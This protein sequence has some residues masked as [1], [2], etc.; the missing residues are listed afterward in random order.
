MNFE[1]TI[2]PD[3]ITGWK[4]SENLYGFE[5]FAI[6]TNKDVWEDSINSLWTLVSPIMT[7]A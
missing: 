6:F 2:Q 7:I 1:S 4:H 3:L 5:A